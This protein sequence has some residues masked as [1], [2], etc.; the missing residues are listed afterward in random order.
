[1]GWVH[2]AGYNRIPKTGWFVKK[3]C[4]YSFMVLKVGKFKIGWVNLVI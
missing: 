3:N 4:F 1:V 2:L